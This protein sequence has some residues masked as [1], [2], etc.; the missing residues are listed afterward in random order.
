MFE[1]LIVSVVLLYYLLTYN[2][3]TSHMCILWAK[4]DPYYFWGQEDMVNLE[5]LHLLRGGGGLVSL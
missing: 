1:L 2:Y 4:E 3:D 5:S